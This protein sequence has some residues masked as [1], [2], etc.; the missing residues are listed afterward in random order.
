[1]ARKTVLKYSNDPLVRKFREVYLPRIVAAFDP[2]EVWLFGSRVRGDA[3]VE[4]DLDAIVVSEAFAGVAWPERM[5]CVARA[6]DLKNAIEIL[7]YTP[8][9]FRGKREE[10]GIVQAAVEEGRRVHSKR[11][12]NT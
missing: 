6:A 8:E 4:S 11:R 3:M 2:E 10:L 9:E 7:C 5:V 1:M 12:K